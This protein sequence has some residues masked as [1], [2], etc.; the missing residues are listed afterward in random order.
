MQH[1][2]IM[3]ASEKL[4]QGITSLKPAR[5]TNTH[6]LSK[7]QKETAYLQSQILLKLRVVKSGEP[8]LGN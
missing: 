6:T 1:T 4:R 8:R 7:E 2:F 5:A 3:L